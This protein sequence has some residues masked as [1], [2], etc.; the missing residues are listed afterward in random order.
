MKEPKM[1]VV[2]ERRA[3]GRIN[4]GELITKENEE[5]SKR[6]LPSVQS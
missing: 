2:N 6:E 5:I 3:N 4:D 1:L